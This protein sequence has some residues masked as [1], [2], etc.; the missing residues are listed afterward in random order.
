LYKALQH[1][2]SSLPIRLELSQALLGTNA[3]AALDVLDTAPESQK[4]STPVLVQRNWVFLA[5]GDM[6]SMRAS[7][8]LGLSR[9]KSPEL[10]L[11]DGLWKLRAGD[12]GAAQVALEASLNGN[13]GEVRALA[14]LNEAYFA[15]K[16]G[17]IAIEKVK[18]Y[19]SKL[20]DSAPVQQFLGTMLW[21]TGD[22]KGARTAF[23]AA[24]A[25]DK[26]F[27]TA[28]LA[29]AQMDAGEGKID[30]SIARVRSILLADSGN[31]TAQLWLGM[32][33]EVKGNHDVALEQFRDVVRKDPNNAKALNNLASL[34]A[35]YANK[36]DE[37][38]PYAQKAVEIGPD[39]PEFADTLGWVLYRKGLY[40]ASVQQLER[41]AA[42]QDKPIWKFHL[43]MAYSKLGDV[44]R[45]RAA[46]DAGLKMNPNVPEA[47]LAKDMLAQVK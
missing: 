6:K 20:P 28:K 23:E 11:Q 16:K 17:L 41:A 22:I 21:A 4:Q 5:L 19:A 31:V 1:D 10:L 40:A 36:P 7:I 32:L 35:E 44:K 8:D 47:K 24:I 39:N 30:E 38:L 3:K 13:P 14:A 9:E 34:L 43:A 33:E 26:N 45:G 25:S 18:A 37:A 2:S 27:V 46:L 29:L 42:H 12:F 15:Q